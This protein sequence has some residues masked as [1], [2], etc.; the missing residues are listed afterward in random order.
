MYN[1]N[2]EMINK[3]NN[4]LAKIALIVLGIFIVVSVSIV[5]FD[6]YKM[7][8]EM[9]D[10]TKW[11]IVN[12]T[13]FSN[14]DYVND[15][16]GHVVTSDNNV[17]EIK[18][19]G[20][21]VAKSGGTATI[22]VTKKIQDDVD[23]N[24]KTKTTT[25][26]KTNKKS[27]TSKSDKLIDVYDSLE[28]GESVEIE[29][30]VDEK[31]NSIVLKTM[32]LNLFV[33]ESSN[34]EYGIM[35]ASA[36]NK[37]VS[38]TSSDDSIVAVDSKG[39]VS[40][41]SEGSATIVV[42]ALDGSKKSAKCKVNVTKKEIV[43]KSITLIESSKTLYVGDKYLLDPVV[44]PN[45]NLKSKIVYTSSDEK[46]ATVDK[47]GNI[48][49]KK[50]G[51]ANITLTL[52]DEKISA[53]FK[54]IV[55]NVD[56]SSVQVSPHSVTLET[57]STINLQTTISPNNATNK[58]VTYTSSNSS[59]ATVSS[60]GK[61][62]AISSGNC[63]IT[64]TSNNNKT[65]I[66]NVTVN[67]KVIP[68]TSV[69]A[70]IKNESI[71]I[72]GTTSISATVNPSN[73]TDKTLTYTSSN[74]KVA[75]VDNK[76]I[77][78]AISPGTVTITVATSS[79]L[80][81]NLSLIVT[82]KFVNKLVIS[83]AN[84][85][86][87]I[88]KTTQLTTT[89]T[90]SDATNKGVTYTSSNN[91]I[92][93]VSQNGIVTGISQGEV[94]ITVSTNDGSNLKTSLKI[95][96]LP[97]EVSAIKVDKT[98]VKMSK[99]STVT[100]KTTI[101]PSTATN[102]SVTYKSSN[103]KVATVSS[104]GVIKGVSNGKATVTITS[105]DNTN[106]KTSV[107]VEVKEQTVASISL[108]KQRIILD[109]GSSTTIKPTVK[110]DI[111]N[112]PSLPTTWKSANTSIA[113]VSN[114][115]KVTAKKLGKTYL[116]VTVGSK[117]ES[118]PVYV[119]N[120]G[121]KM[122]FIDVED[123]INTNG[124]LNTNY[125]IGDAILVR[126]TNKNGN[127]IYG[128][129]DT[130]NSYFY[131]R[132]LSYLKDLNVKE[133]EWVLI[134]HNRSD[135]YGNFYHGEG[136]YKG[137]ITVKGLY[138]K[139][140]D[141]ASSNTSKNSVDELRK[142]YASYFKSYLDKAKSKGTKIYCVGN[143][144]NSKKVGTGSG[145][146]KTDY[147]FKNNVNSL[148]LG[149]FNFKLY[150]TADVYANKQDDCKSTLSCDENTNSIVAVATV[151]GKN[152]VLTGDVDSSIG[153]NVATQIK[154]DYHNIDIYKMPN[155]T[156]KGNN[157]EKVSKIYSPTYAVGTITGYYVNIRSSTLNS[158]NQYPYKYSNYESIN[159]MLAAGVKGQNIYYSGDGTVLFNIDGSGKISTLQFYQ[160]DMDRDMDY[161]VY[162]SQVDTR[163]YKDKY[164]NVPN[165]NI[166]TSG[167]APTSIAMVMSTITGISGYGPS[168]TVKSLCNITG[169][170]QAG[171]TTFGGVT[172]LLNQYGAL[173]PNGK[174]QVA[175]QYYKDKDK[176]YDCLKKNTCMAVI[177]VQDVNGKHTFTTGGHYLA[178]TGMANASSSKSINDAKLTI[179]NP[180]MVGLDQYRYNK[181][182]TFKDFDANTRGSN[183]KDPSAFWLIKK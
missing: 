69:N 61:I 98:S 23:S 93:T 156:I 54:V 1:N 17:V 45:A 121:N 85:S 104:S 31:V 100:L 81:S 132:I 22:T 170:C 128:L 36:T 148:T 48:I 46:V 168:D 92:A 179:A 80:K 5:F 161:V 105:V 44:Q 30:V 167:C 137:G 74:T 131:D 64:V 15:D 152:I 68:V 65:D 20:D 113:T 40:A 28:E 57:G 181:T 27:T 174:S 10:R 111:T 129:I 127:Y 107:E 6:Q 90:P 133:L 154:K 160:E 18:S 38:W 33:G 53:T 42:S 139:Q 159:G 94:T 25:K 89:I 83:S 37:K 143:W 115:G 163:W 182:Y 106:I 3:N 9:K 43:E 75:T 12:G 84:S 150:N 34:L 56:V 172:K 110:Y 120:S 144:L 78:K 125:V 67:E 7:Y 2:G 145:T 73:A 157:P 97:I 77:V 91:K 14:T 109:K 52:K 51:N 175:Y 24:N 32:E 59:I 26:K 173:Q 21:I 135:H 140:Y 66:V 82:P 138:V 126:S 11:Y 176:L 95:K 117:S 19:N 119:S 70:S 122:F 123:N 29:V 99:N 124:S 86:I 101:S 114:D 87:Y 146:D 60:D 158:K 50:E 8:K 136:L 47:N 134:T 155:H 112:A 178:I 103:T 169:A 166:N 16:G 183:Y 49:A 171:G 180:G 58:N 41:K 102:K 153:E 76:G 147:C 151:K 88:G 149:D 62:T 35:P 164:G 142:N 63:N 39:K 165:K 71:A 118:I 162:Y 79:G 108:P 116:T 55:K 13:V 177:H 96:V 141:R 130:G 4:T 72:G